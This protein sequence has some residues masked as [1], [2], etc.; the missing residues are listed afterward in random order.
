MSTTACKPAADYRTD[1]PRGDGW[2]YERQATFLL[3]LSETGL[4]SQACKFAE[5]SVASAYALR[6]EARGRAFALGWQAAHLL[7]RDRLED[8]LLEAAIAGVE[9]VST[10]VDGVTRRRCLNANLS[11]AVLNRLDKRAAALDDRAV[12]V[13]RAIGAAFEDFIT[14][15]LGGCDD[16]AIDAFLGGHPDPLGAQVEVYES[17]LRAKRGNPVSAFGILDCRASLAMTSCE[18]PAPTPQF[19]EKSAIFAN[20]LV[21]TGPRIAPATALRASPVPCSCPADRELALLEAA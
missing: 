6:R 19:V 8:L 11:M 9:S 14:L 10:R 3:T 5:M 4:V 13:A 7:A 21:S 15:V 16:A 2:T 18:T 12:G 20:S 17:S 1:A